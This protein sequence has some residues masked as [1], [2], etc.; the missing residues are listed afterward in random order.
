MQ[1]NL[2]ASI[3][4]DRFSVVEGL[5]EQC[6]LPV[7]DLNQVNWYCFALLEQKGKIIALGGLEATGKEL[8]LRS[9]AVDSDYRNQR[10]AE[11]IVFELFNAIDNSQYSEVYLMTLDAEDY[12]SRRFA[13]ASIER[14]A[15][16][17]DIRNS[18][19]F[20]GVCPASATLMKKNLKHD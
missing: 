16:P 6:G 13:F 1:I 20:L 17:E 9:V 7:S 10:F 11:K 2:S 18:T 15:A 4:K 14:D 5:V 8:L 12:F 3:P 19:Q